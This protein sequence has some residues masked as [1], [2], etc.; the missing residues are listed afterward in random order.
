MGVLKIV[1]QPND[2]V[3]CNT[4]INTILLKYLREVL[5]FKQNVTGEVIFV[6]YLSDS[7]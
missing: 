3:M 7:S 1:L 6:V 4:K 2:K 5:Y